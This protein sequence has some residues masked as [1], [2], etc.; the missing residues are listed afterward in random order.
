M[1]PEIGNDEQPNFSRGPANGV[2]G[3]RQNTT[4]KRGYRV[5]HDDKET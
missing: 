4:V 5:V 2:T 1:L 3:I